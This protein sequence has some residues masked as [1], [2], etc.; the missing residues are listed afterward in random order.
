[1]YFLILASNLLGQDTEYWM[2]Y[3]LPRPKEGG[4]LGLRLIN[5]LHDKQES[6]MAA[7][8]LIYSYCFRVGERESRSQLSRL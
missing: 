3:N 4:T 7:E 2:A 1:M 5:T 8:L 6:L